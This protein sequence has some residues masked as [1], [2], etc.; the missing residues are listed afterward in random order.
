MMFSEKV[1]N[2]LILILLFGSINLIE[3]PSKC[4]RRINH[5]LSEYRIVGGDLSQ[6][7]QWPWQVFINI[8]VDFGLIAKQI[9]CGGSIV[10]EN[11]ILTAAHCVPH[12]VRSGLKVNIEAI[13][14]AVDLKNSNG[15]RRKVVRWLAH[16]KFDYV[17]K[18]NDI[19]L[20]QL[21]E[22]VSFDDNTKLAPICLSKLD[23]SKLRIP[24]CYATGFGFENRFFR[25]NDH[26]LRH[27]K[28]L[29]I[30]E[31]KCRQYYPDINNSTQI[32]V[33]A[34][35][36]GGHGTCLGDSGGPLQCFHTDKNRWYQIGLISY[37]EPCALPETPDVFTKIEYFYDWILQ[38]Q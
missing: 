5:S 11:W 32:C 13:F 15:I 26:Q 16:E 24:I 2:V 33:D 12:F 38:Q 19:A 29:I 7:N 14:G 8:T 23:H 22:S 35:L 27:V 18:Q 28:E 20:M 17:N 37:G 9:N 36:G 34:D 6:I 21:N 3:L 1:S 31:R 30:D 4:G 10:N 25:Q